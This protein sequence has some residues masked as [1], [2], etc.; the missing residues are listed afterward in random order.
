M[1][2][3]SYVGIIPSAE[4]DGAW[5]RDGYKRYLMP[6]DNYMAIGFHLFIAIGDIDGTF[7]I[8]K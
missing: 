2:I 4:R 8:V 6:G 5:T 1:V 3:W 7:S